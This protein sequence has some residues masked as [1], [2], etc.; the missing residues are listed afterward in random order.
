[1]LSSFAEFAEVLWTARYDYAPGSALQPHEHDHSQIIYCVDGSGAF[2]LSD[3]EYPLSPGSLFLIKP[4]CR[5]GLQ[6]E[7]R[8]KTLD[9]KFVV[10]DAFLQRSLARS[11]AVVQDRG[12]VFA[13][14]LE[15][16][17][18]E[19]ERKHPLHREMCT[20][21]LMQIL[22]GCLRERQP[23]P[24]DVPPATGHAVQ[25]VEDEVARRAI[26]FI[27]IHYAADLSLRDISQALSCSDR[28]VRFR[29][30]ESLGI[31]PM[32][33]LVQFRVEKARELIERFDYSLKEV[34]E[35]VGFKSIHHFTRVFHK[36][37]GET[38][39]AWRRKYRAGICKDI[40]IDP[41]FSNV[42]LVVS[43]GA[44]RG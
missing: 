13:S 26:E 40:C 43:P 19:G 38:P 16:I 44:A 34:A 30:E 39:A 22:L 14:L 2:Y 5:H 33:Y 11:P 7:S 12:A 32:R 18:A 3:R 23:Q 29:F 37:S 21:L 35:L 41:R 20:A 28:H 6:A 42:H 36:T 4:G 15:Q 9:L 24:R 31:P 17:R 25:R 10:K 27:Q 8:V 1:M